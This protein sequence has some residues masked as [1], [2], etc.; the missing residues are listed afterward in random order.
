M[1][2]SHNPWVLGKDATE[3]PLESLSDFQDAVDRLLPQARRTARIFVPEL[4]IVL[5]SRE[6]VVAALSA[7]VKISRY[8]HI[9]ILF[10]DASTA[11]RSG[12][13]LIALGQRFPSY[14]SLQKLSD[15]DRAS[16][17]WIVLDERAV[18]Y[19]RD[20]N[21]YSEGYACAY[22]RGRAA[23]LVTQ[24]DQLWEASRPDPELRRLII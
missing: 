18:I 24:F 7:M 21:R 6:P 14:I 23:R 20:Y 16:P 1:S 8:T 9:R 5:L 2:E 11:V 15:P 10:A 19:R 17:A 4:D 3:H 22:Q 12:H 13:R